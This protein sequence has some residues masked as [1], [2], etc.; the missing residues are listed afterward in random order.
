MLRTVVSLGVTTVG[1]VAS[2]LWFRRS[3]ARNDITVTL[4]RR[5]A[6]AK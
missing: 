6:V 1:I 2:C 5:R 3:M 4:L